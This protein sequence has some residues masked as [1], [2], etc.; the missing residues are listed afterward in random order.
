MNKIETKHQMTEHRTLS[1]AIQVQQGVEGHL[2][3]GNKSSSTAGHGHKRFSTT[4]K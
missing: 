3:D 2:H 4:I 1:P